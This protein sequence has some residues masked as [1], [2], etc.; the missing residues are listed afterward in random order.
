MVLA[1][2]DPA[3]AGAAPADPPGVLPAEICVLRYAIEHHAQ[4]KGEATF[5]VFEGGER[6]T[7]AQTLER[8]RRTAAGL[9][10]LGVRQG[11]R[12]VVMM[13]NCSWSV[14]AL[15]AINYLGA[16]FVPINPAYR[17]ALL[18]HVLRDSGAA[19]AI[20]HPALRER[21][22][23]VPV[24]ALRRI[25]VAAHDI[26][27]GRQGD[28]MI[29]GADALAADPAMLPPLERPIAPW[30][31]QSI[32]YTSGTT[33]RS[34]GVLSS[35]M[36]SYSAMSPQTWTCTRADDRH[37]LHMPIFHIGGAFIACVAFCAGASIGVV[38]SFRT[39]SFWRSVRELR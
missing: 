20:I 19:L 6:W 33:G 23:E 22:L 31:D 25:V 24:P 28:I 4:A 39:D 7:F 34:K 27:A 17:G 37:L 35:Y 14:R 9:A 36:H 5:A 16:V 3:G 1:P 12:V 26:E 10:R 8:V 2:H 15:F 38:E 18:E 29:A 32:I 11:D 21:V 13:P 30:H